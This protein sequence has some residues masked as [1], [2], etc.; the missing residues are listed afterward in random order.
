MQLDTRLNIAAQV[1]TRDLGGE[2]VILNLAQ[3]AY[4]SL[5]A[6]GSRVWQLIAEGL[7]LGEICQA[8]L[9]EYE[10]PRAQLEQ[11]VFDLGQVLLSKQ[12]VQIDS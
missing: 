6:V 5:N 7:T 4:H 12:L 9:A 1:M 8:M 10:V 3:G 11:D 2:T